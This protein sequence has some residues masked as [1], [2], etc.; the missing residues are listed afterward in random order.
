MATAQFGGGIDV[1]T[2]LKLLF[3]IGLRG[4]FRDFYTLGKPVSA[5]RSSAQNSIIS[6]SREDWSSTF[7]Q[8]RRGHPLVNME[9]RMLDR[10]AHH[11]S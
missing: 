1:R 9:D 3:T 2:R 4:E 8:L 11:Q 6:S 5:F 7:S 10:F